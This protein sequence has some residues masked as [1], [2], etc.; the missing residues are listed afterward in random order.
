[1]SNSSVAEILLCLHLSIRLYIGLHIEQG[2]TL[3]LVQAMLAELVKQTLEGS[4][5]PDNGNLS[6]YLLDQLD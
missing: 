1:M 4:C 2:T 5:I 3:T 6:T